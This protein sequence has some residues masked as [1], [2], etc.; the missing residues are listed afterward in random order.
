MVVE[1]YIGETL[2]GFIILS[3]RNS[4]DSANGEEEKAY[5]SPASKQRRDLPLQG[6]WWTFGLTSV[7]ITLADGG[8]A[9]QGFPSES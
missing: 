5:R 1:N 2:F 4:A 7:G 6:A 8:M 9:D 3:A